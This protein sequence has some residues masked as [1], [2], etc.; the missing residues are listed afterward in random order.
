MSMNGD[1][2]LPYQDPNTPLEERVN[3]LLG[4]MT[5]EEKCGQLRQG[6]LDNLR[7]FN[8]TVSVESLERGFRDAP[9]GVVRMEEGADA[10]TNAVKARDL[11][12]YLLEKSRLGIP[13]LFIVAGAAGA[14]LGGLTVFPS[15]LA[16]GATWDRELVREVA[17]RIAVE[18]AAAGA[19]QL[20]APSF[21]LG[22]D[23][24]FG[25]ISHCFG[26]CPTLVTE[27]G[28]AFLE[29]LQGD[30]ATG[31][32]GAGK[33]FWEREDDNTGTP[34]HADAPGL[35]PNKVFAT[36]LGFT[37]WGC[38][39]GGLH[40]APVSLSTRAL[41]ALHFPPFED[42]VRRGRAQCVVPVISPV[43]SVP[44]HANGW[45]LGTVLHS[46]W[47]FTGYVL[48]E[49]GGIAL[50]HS[51]FGIAGDMRGAAAQAL[52]AGVDVDAAGH[53]DAARR[54]Q[55]RRLRAAAAGGVSGPPPYEPDESPSAFAALAAAVRDGRAPEQDVNR[56]VARLLRVKFL[57]GLFDRRR[58]LEPDA[59]PKRLRAKDSAILARRAAAGGVILL[60]NS[61]D[62]LPLD[63]ARIK[64]LAVIGPNADTPQFGDLAFR[65]EDTPGV[66]LLQGLKN[67]LGN[68]VRLLHARGCGVTGAALRPDMD[69]AIAV[70]KRGDVVL[71]VLG[72][73]SAPP[74]SAPAG[75]RGGAAPT[76]GIGYDTAN[77]VLPGA[78]GDL[79]RALA[80]TG[81]PLVVI[82]VHGRPYSEPWLKER[83]DAVLSC[84]F[85]GEEQGSALA[86]VLFGECDPGGRLPVSVARG[87]GALPTTYDHTP[88]AR[89][90]Y[91]RAGSTDFPGRDYV[92]DECA[93]LWPF[94]FGLSY[95]RFRYS[96]LE[97][98]TPEVT[99][100]GEVRLRFTVANLSKRAGTDV[101]QVYFHNATSMVAGPQMRLARFE[102]FEVA[103]G[104]ERIVRVAFPVS[105]MAEWDRLMR[106][107]V[108]NPGRYEILVGA[109][110][111]DIALRGIVTLKSAAAAGTGGAVFSAQ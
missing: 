30:L 31:A 51:L 10:L 95:A 71:V 77:P 63:A 8:G 9:P 7:V 23:P 103:A 102:K 89:G 81:K 17:A 108:A 1:A 38:A 68:R 52:A 6:R 82:L 73:E 72:D 24:R 90:I 85:A 33:G 93:P 14:C 28:L 42:A 37:G 40:G 57:A 20:L 55:E 98:E 50:N 86:D 106:V 46:E 101:A 111:E 83:A 97:I 19:T 105:A 35:A 44:A 65:R 41:R 66:S 67:L 78:Q 54:A 29:G 21:A 70:A 45:L 2:L 61:D 69:S 76:A 59:L 107:R 26:E 91:A 12:A 92:F 25:G 109:S 4:R 27:M 88:G 96:A 74:P 32:A 94:G 75:T 34:R 5:I 47:R 79:L 13:P 18:A 87:A 80:E 11:N 16:L 56:A 104:D 3:D 53:P 110:A 84:Y 64:T 62:L 48:A 22:R 60:K 99:A 39:D 49:T 36:A 100:D 43:N 15:P 58:V